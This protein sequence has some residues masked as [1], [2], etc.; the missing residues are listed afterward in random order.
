MPKNLVGEI[1]HGSPEEIWEI[2]IGLMPQLFDIL[3]HCVENFCRNTA[4]NPIVEN[5]DNDSEYINLLKF[6]LQIFS[7][8]FKRFLYKILNIKKILN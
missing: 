5:S 8:I 7:Q 6:V 2:I 4:Q 3:S 1:E